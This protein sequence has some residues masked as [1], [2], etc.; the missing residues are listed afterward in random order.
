MS[1][2]RADGQRLLDGDEEVQ[3]HWKRNFTGFLVNFLLES[4]EGGYLPAFVIDCRPQSRPEIFVLRKARQGGL[5][6]LGTNLIHCRR[7]TRVSFA[8]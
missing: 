7:K 3:N 1:I 4:R 5:A 8:I 2:S 6:F